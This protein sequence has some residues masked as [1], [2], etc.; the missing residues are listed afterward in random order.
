MTDEQI[1][2]RK[3]NTVLQAFMEEAHTMFRY[4]AEAY[5]L[6]MKGN[7]DGVNTL[8][9]KADETVFKKLLS[10]K[11]AMTTEA[12]R[13]YSVLPLGVEYVRACLLIWDAACIAKRII[14][15]L[16]GMTRRNW[17]EKTSFGDSIGLITLS[18]LREFELLLK[19]VP[20]GSGEKSVRNMGGIDE[21]FAQTTR[22]IDSVNK[23]L[24]NEIDKS[25]PLTVLYNLTGDLEEISKKILEA[26]EYIT[27]IASA[28]FPVG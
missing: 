25:P 14:Q 3:M 17:V 28:D 9:L 20:V 26:A 7:G 18:L 15:K 2:A 24:L 21:Q 12:A 5:D 6:F 19:L 23:L 4:L 10:H 27:L 1:L 11:H 16:E 8:I 13:A 22:Y